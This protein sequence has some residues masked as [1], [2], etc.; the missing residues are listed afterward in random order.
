MSRCLPREAK[1][2]VCKK[3]LKNLMSKS[4]DPTREL[5]ALLEIKQISE[6]DLRRYL[7]M[8]HPPSNIN[9]LISKERK[10]I[11]DIDY[12]I[13]DLQAQIAA[14]EMYTHIQ[15]EYNC[16]KKFTNLTI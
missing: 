8:D 4:I 9:N 7:T 1:A 16:L 6:T 15:Q 14:A 3:P 13:F 11:A 10:V 5:E 2:D 12:L